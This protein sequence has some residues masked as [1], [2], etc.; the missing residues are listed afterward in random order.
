M[1]VPGSRKITKPDGDYY[2]REII[3]VSTDFGVTWTEHTISDDE[4]LDVDEESFQMSS[5]GSRMALRTGDSA[6]Y[7]WMSTDFG[8]TWNPLGGAI[9][10]SVT[11]F[12]FDNTLTKVVWNTGNEYYYSEDC[13]RTA[14]RIP[15]VD[16]DYFYTF[17]GD[18]STLAGVD[19][20]CLYI[21]TN[22]TAPKGGQ[23]R[24]LTG[25][26]NA[27]VELQYIG[28]GKF[29]PISSAGSISVQTK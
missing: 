3:F 21:Y 4:D 16:T 10:E 29:I 14:V 2:Y 11:F 9:A 18:G 7:V 20:P 27:S 1:A 23:I 12:R 22:N 24:Y 26:N 13:G 25:S 6:G 5:D 15:Y 8:V 17:S 28:D 19:Y